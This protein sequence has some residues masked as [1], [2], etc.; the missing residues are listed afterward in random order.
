MRSYLNHLRTLPAFR[1]CTRHDLEVIARIVEEV[2]LSPGERVAPNGREVRV[3]MSP[4]R[5][6]VIGRRALPTLATLA[7]DLLTSTALGVGK[8]H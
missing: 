8:E 4:T 6:L 2:E 5:V 3:M 7:P 1:C